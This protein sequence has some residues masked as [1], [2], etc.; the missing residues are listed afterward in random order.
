M[1]KC[2]VLLVYSPNVPLSPV[3]KLLEDRDFAILLSRNWEEAER[4]RALVPADQLKYIFL[5]ATL[6]TGAGWEQF[7]YRLQQ[8]AADVI[9]VSFHPRFPHTLAQLL[10]HPSNGA[11]ADSGDLNPRAPVVV[12]ESA[13]FQ[14]VLKLAQ[15]YAHYDITVLVTGETGAGKEVM[16]RYIHAHSS[17]HDKPLV[18]C[19]LTAIPD[20]LVLDRAG[21]IEARVIGKITYPGLKRLLDQALK[22]ETVAGTRQ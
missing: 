12:G 20:T 17:R 19:N 18:A 22:P 7:L 1:G 4:A 2:Q 9:C 3:Q 6:C 5:D 15:R 16:A 14:A 10:N 13:S 8:A 21:D 11:G